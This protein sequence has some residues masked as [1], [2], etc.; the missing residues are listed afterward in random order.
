MNDLAVLD[1]EPP[2]LSDGPMTDPA[3]M[4]L[5][6]ARADGSP[7][8]SKD[9]V[10]AMLGIAETVEASEGE[11]VAELPLPNEIKRERRERSKRLRVIEPFIPFQHLIV[12]EKPASTRKFGAV[13][14]AS[15]Q[16]AAILAAL[17]IRPFPRFEP[18]KETA[19]SRQDEP[20][21]VLFEAKAKAKS[22]VL[23]TESLAKNNAKPGPLRTNIPTRRNLERTPS[24]FRESVVTDEHAGLYS[25]NSDFQAAADPL[26]GNEALK[27]ALNKPPAPMVFAAG[28]SH[29]VRVAGIEPTYP[30]IARMRNVSG[31][32]VMRCVV[33]TEGVARDC[34]IHKS[35]AYLDE[36]VLAASRTWRFAPAMDKGR[37]VAVFYVFKIKFQLG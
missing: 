13:M 15:L 6:S 36:A 27:M 37:P 31:T 4:L 11:R 35:P 20:E 16:V 30:V 28:M 24:A 33:T 17:F 1:R 12:P 9:R 2:R 3:A 7:K 14:V 19:V 34:L 5:R 26:A 10:R 22:T 32:V 18:P 29:P 25:E 21:M 23:P 8:G